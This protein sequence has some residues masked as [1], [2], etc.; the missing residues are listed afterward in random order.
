MYSLPVKRRTWPSL[1][2]CCSRS[3]ALVPLGVGELARVGADDLEHEAHRVAHLGEQGDPALEVG[4]GEQ[5]LEAP[6][7]AGL[8]G[9]VGDAGQAA[10]PRRVEL[11]VGVPLLA[12]QR[13]DQVRVQVRDLGLVE[14]LDP[15]EPDH[16]GRHPVGEHHH[17]AL[18]RLA[19]AELVAHLGVELGVVVDVV[20]VVDGDAG[21]LLEDVERRRLLL[22]RVDVRR[23][24][25]DD[26]RHLLGGDVGRRAELRVLLGARDLEERQLQ[27]GQADA[28][29]G[30][31]AA[32]LEQ[33]RG[34]TARSGGSVTPAPCDS[35]QGRSARWLGSCHAWGPR[36]SDPVEK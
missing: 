26:Q 28:R 4:A 27:R 11:E 12:A 22:L 9:V 18:D 30:D 32:A 29:E 33:A 6:H 8:R 16:P 10:L 3:I 23:P 31:D 15:A 35:L 21:A 20:G 13:V 25:G 24:V 19:G 36:T 34:E 5:L 17:V 1:T 2:A 14:R 7:L